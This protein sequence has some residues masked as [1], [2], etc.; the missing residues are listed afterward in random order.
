MTALP[1]V[2]PVTRPPVVTVATDISP[3][4][5]APPEVT[6]DNRLVPPIHIVGVPEIAAGNGLTVIPL[7][8]KHPP[9]IV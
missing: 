2:T 4:L 1:T 5:H 8:T 7:L 9:G 3:L 6:E